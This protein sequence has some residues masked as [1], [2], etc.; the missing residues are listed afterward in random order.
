LLP[1]SRLRYAAAAAAAPDFAEI[2]AAI[3]MLQAQRNDTF[4]VTLDATA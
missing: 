1:L 2:D 4:V 3:A